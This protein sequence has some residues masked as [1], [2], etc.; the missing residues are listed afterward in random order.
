MLPH[1]TAGPMCLSPSKLALTVAQPVDRIC[2]QRES[3]SKAAACKHVK[4]NQTQC[5]LRGVQARPESLESINGQPH[6]SFVTSAC[7]P[8][9]GMPC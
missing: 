3:S 8:I 1:Q 2:Q 4:L 9:T 5:S 7:A 6:T